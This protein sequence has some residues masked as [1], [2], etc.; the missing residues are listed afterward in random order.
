MTPWVSRHYMVCDQDKVFM[1]SF[2]KQ[3]F[4]AQNTTLKISSAYHPQI[5]GAT[6]VV[7][8]FLE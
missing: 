4:K 6:E 5:D 3:Y 8:R 1:S 7:T 2:S